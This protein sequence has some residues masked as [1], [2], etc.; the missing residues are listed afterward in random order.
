MDKTL[1][2]R[3]IKQQESASLDFKRELHKIFDQNGTTKSG[4][5]DELIRDILSLANGN[6]TT[7]GETA[8]LIFGI[9]EEVNSSGER[10]IYG[11]TERI[12]SA[13]DILSII[14]PA[15]A[16][17]IEDILCELFEID[18]K[19]IF[20][21]T[22][23]PS[24]YLHETT[25]KLKTSQK[26]YSEHVVFIRR[27]ES[28]EIASAKERVAIQDLKKYRHDESNRIDPVIFGAINGAIVSGSI[29]AAFT[30][31]SDQPKNRK[32]T[33][34]LASYILGFIVGGIIGNACKNIIRFKRD[35]RV[36][37]AK[38]RPITVVVTVGISL[39]VS[40]IVR[41]LLQRIVH[42]SQPMSS[43]V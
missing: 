40:V 14:K 7:A 28:I 17:P 1:L 11:V 2:E 21:V 34:I 19:Q 23:F 12:P 25:R 38:W 20:V 10:V 42:R 29:T 41:A 8:F 13:K 18:S 4:H 5:R 32:N 27:G 15:S 16:P 37:P 39:G 6:T 43:K 30:E 9:D 3:L 36:I 35:I 33:L 31:I 22:I 24:P 26:Q